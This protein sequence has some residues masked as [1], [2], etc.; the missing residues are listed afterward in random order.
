MAIIVPNSMLI[1]ETVINHSRPTTRLRIRVPVGVAYGSSLEKV[2]S[3]LAK[4]AAGVEGVL[5]D[6]KPEVRFEAFDDSSL[7]FAVLVWV[8]EPRHDLKIASTLRF[9]I[10]ECL[11]SAAIEIPF[12]Q[13]DIHVRSMPT[14]S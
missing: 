5:K 7:A 2:C 12:P 4:A 11:R 6:P 10:T 13:R 9:A 8:D 1:T 3:A 14:R